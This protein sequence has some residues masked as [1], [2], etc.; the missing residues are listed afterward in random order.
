MARETALQYDAVPAVDAAPVMM[1]LSE[2][3]NI[4][5]ALPHLRLAACVWGPATGR[6]VLALHGWL[7]NA[8]SFDRLAPLLPGLRIV[9]LDLPG[10]GH[11]DHRPPGCR[12]HF[13]DFVFDAVAAADA[14]GWE[15]F[16]L[17]GHS[18]GA[19]VACCLAAGAP[20][21]VGRLA[22]IDGLG[23]L[24]EPISNTPARLARALDEIRRPQSRP[25]VYPDVTAAALARRRATGLT[26]EA[27]TL[28][29]ERGIRRIADGVIWRSD[30]RLVRISPVYLSEPQVRALLGAIRA[31]AILIQARDGLLRRRP[32]M[33][34]RLSAL[35]DLE[36][37]E[38]TGGHHLHL[39]QP[40][41]VA[42]VLRGFWG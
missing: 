14:L 5:L 3:A 30:S 28:L 7:D 37:V 29:V 31:P 41:P 25:T 26:L 15:R 27:A 18:L 21:R 13:I 38:L 33:T 20:D 22:L 23:P 34:G 10:H 17:L 4:E 36:Q 2:S 8:A 35:P 32:E 40:E 11:S 9:A 24:T 12:Y 39:E 1:S 19:A 42:K 6:P 16:D